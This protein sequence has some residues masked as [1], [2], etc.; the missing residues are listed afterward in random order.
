MTPKT[1]FIFDSYALLAYLGGESGQARVKDVLLQ[2]RDEKCH[3]LLCMINFG[4]V[5]YMTERRRGFAAAQSVQAMIENMPIE[6]VDVTRNLVLDA[7]HMKANYTL[8]Y[9][10]AFV[11]ALAQRENGI[12]LTGDPEFSN[13]EKLIHLEWLK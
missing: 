3:L 11:V 4:E 12:V 6:I 8:S 1:I 2:T 10:N 5:L 13:V 7:A 9:A